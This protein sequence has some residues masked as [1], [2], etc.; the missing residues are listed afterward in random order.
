MPFSL[1]PA[2]LGACFAFVW[3]FI[4]GMIL[5]DGQFAVRRE[6]EDSIGDTSRAHRAMHHLRPHVRFARRI[7]RAADP[8]R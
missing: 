2:I 7:N 4:G 3:L 5:R 1:I 8:V 6:R